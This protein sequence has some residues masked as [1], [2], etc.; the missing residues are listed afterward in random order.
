MSKKNNKQS[1][2]YINLLKISEEYGEK[3]DNALSSVFNLR[4]VEDIKAFIYDQIKNEVHNMLSILQYADAFDV[5]ELMRLKEFGFNGVANGDGWALVVEIIS[6]ILLSRP[7]RSPEKFNEV[8]KHISEYVPELHFGAKYLADIA[9]I[10]DMAAAGM[11]RN[12]KFANFS[13]IY[14]GY[15]LSVRKLQ[16]D[17]IRRNIEKRLFQNDVV[18]S[19]MEKYLGYTSKDLYI[20]QDAVEGILARR[21]TDLRDKAG[22][23]AA[24]YSDHP[25]KNISQ[26]EKDVFMDA[27]N[28][29]IFFPGDRA[30][31]TADDIISVTDLNVELVVRILD[32]YSQYFSDSISPENRVHRLLTQ[33]NA[34]LKKP[35]VS[36]G[37]ENWILTTVNP[38]IDSLRRILEDKLSGNDKDLR[39]YDRIRSK[40]S[41][42]MSIEC[43]KKIFNTGSI[44]SNLYYYVPKEG[45]SIDCVNSS[46]VD[47]KN[48]ANR[49]ECDGLI[50]I[51]DVAIILEVKAKSFSNKAREGS[52]NRIKRDAQDTIGSASN[53]LNRFYELIKINGGFWSGYDDWVDLS[54]IREIRSIVVLLDDIGPAASGLDD[55]QKLQ[56]L[57]SSNFPWV[58]S[59]HDLMVIADICER[60]GEFLLYIR[61]R[62]EGE[63]PK[64]FHAS[65][66]LD[67][68]M[69]FIQGKL[70]VED[71]PDEVHSKYP[72][73]SVRKVDRR[74]HEK[75]AV[76]TFIG[77]QCQTLNEWYALDVRY[78]KRVE[79][80]RFRVKDKV[81]SI[82]DYVFDKN[83]SGWLRFS[84]DIFG[85]SG[86]SQKEF[87]NNFSSICRKCKQDGSTHT[88][89][90]SYA[91]S[92]GNPSIFVLVTSDV[93]G[94]RL[95]REWLLSYMQAKSY[96]LRS[97][98]SY[99]FISDSDG[100][101]L[102]FLYLT[103]PPETDPELDNLITELGLQP[104]GDGSRRKYHPG[105]SRKKSSKS[106]KHSRRKKGSRKMRKKKR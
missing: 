74:M 17:H 13:A 83:F 76:K 96:Q 49:A 66:E 18:S 12:N 21:L 7:S 27:I 10:A 85:I 105:V 72:T 103:N 101:I 78:H 28:S 59:L 75:D 31:I 8:K 1:I 54:Y 98:R 81:A 3:Y 53:Q 77:N 9:L 40:V 45:L 97:D 30:T 4:N 93:L 61:R 64:Y 44:Y 84:A 2:N 86:N 51:D 24:E 14:R 52:F 48:T 35:L 79:K 94:L 6:A 70:Y 82:A 26:L 90:S 60:P 92:W 39:K 56:I 99:G 33:E 65:D 62:I 23:I 34:F 91:G 38:G 104:V 19:L 42:E 58:V 36:D 57:G 50:L 22:S 89:M 68:F 95:C 73:S 15:I 63:V 32:S 80:P 87:L 47:L 46:C 55:L 106:I 67:Y 88:V 5:I 37:D 41:E 29:L 100:N 25:H 69:L 71:D 102:D 43:I 20:V 11:D 16:Y